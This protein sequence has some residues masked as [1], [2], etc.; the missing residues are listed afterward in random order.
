[1]TDWRQLNAAT[2]RR[3]RLFDD[4][5]WKAELQRL[6]VGFP[7]A[8]ETE[9]TEETEC[10][11]YPCDFGGPIA[12]IVTKT[13]IATNSQARS[14]FHV[15]TAAGTE[16]S[17]V[18]WPHFGLLTGKWADLSTFVAAFKDGTIRSFDATGEKRGFFNILPMGGAVRSRERTLKTAAIGS[19]YI[20]VVTNGGEILVNAS[21]FESKP[22]KIP[23]VPAHWLRSGKAG[24]PT[25]IKALHLTDE[26]SNL[27]L[28]IATS[29][30]GFFKYDGGWHSVKLLPAGS[31]DSSLKISKI[32]VSKS[33]RFLAA[34]TDDSF[35]CIINGSSLLTA[36]Q[37][38]DSILQ[39]KCSL[40]NS[41]AI[42][43]QQI[44]WVA[45]HCLA[46]VVPTPTAFNPKQHC[47]F[48]GGP[49]KRWLDYVQ[50]SWVLISSEIDGL[51]YLT[52]SQSG[53]IQL[54]SEA[55]DA[56]FG[57][58]SCDPAAMVTFAQQRALSLS[59]NEAEEL[60][61][62]ASV[63]GETDEDVSEDAEGDA[64]EAARNESNFKFSIERSR[65]ENS[66]LN[67]FFYHN[68]WEFEKN[69]NPVQ[70]AEFG[71][72]EAALILQSQSTDEKKD[73]LTKILT[74][75]EDEWDP[76]SIVALFKSARLCMDH[77]RMQDNTEM[78]IKYQRLLR[79][80]KML[81]T[82]RNRPA[83]IPLTFHQL[84][85][86][87]L[88]KLV[89]SLFKRRHFD[90]ALSVVNHYKLNPLYY[91]ERELL[92]SENTEMTSLRN[93]YRTS[94]ETLEK[95]VSLNCVNVSVH[96][97]SSTAGLADDELLDS[98][99]KKIGRTFLTDRV[100]ARQAAW[101]A[102]R[103]SRTQFARKLM[104]DEKNH[105]VKMYFCQTVKDYAGMLECGIQTLN[106]NFLDVCLSNIFPF[107]CTSR[108]FDD[109]Q[110]TGTD[111]PHPEY[112]IQSFLTAYNT[113]LKSAPTNSVLKAMLELRQPLYYTMAQLR[114]LSV[115]AEASHPSISFSKSMGLNIEHV[116]N[117]LANIR[118][119][120]I[121]SIDA[122]SGIQEEPTST[123]IDLGIQNT[124]I[125][126]LMT[127]PFSSLTAAVLNPHGASGTEG[128]KSNLKLKQEAHNEY[129]VSLRQLIAHCKS[130]ARSEAVHCLVPI[131]SQ[132]SEILRF[133]AELA[134]LCKS[135]APSLSFVGLGRGNRAAR[136]GTAIIEWEGLSLYKTGETLIFHSPSIPN[137]QKKLEE[138][139]Q[140]FGV[141]KKMFL[142][143]K[144]K[145][146]A[147]R[148]LWAEFLELAIEA[149]RAV[150]LH[151]I[152]RPGNSG[153]LSI[154]GAISSAFN[155]QTV[156]EQS[157]GGAQFAA[158]LSSRFAA[159]LGT[160]STLTSTLSSILAAV[161]GR[162]TSLQFHPLLPDPGGQSSTQ[163]LCAQ[164]LPPSLCSRLHVLEFVNTAIKYDRS[165]IALAL[166]PYISPVSLREKYGVYLGLKDAAQCQKFCH[167]AVESALARSTSSQ[168]SASAGFV[169][170]L[171]SK[172]TTVQRNPLSAWMSTWT[173]NIPDLDSLKLPQLPATQKQPEAA[174]DSSLFVL[175]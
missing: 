32:A 79:D 174:A 62:T 78:T 109:R 26:L 73:A 146:L 175:Q 129:Y 23:P 111:R 139:R 138:F 50:S 127:S 163:P 55:T 61:D 82:L 57:A 106:P 70:D 107:L 47:L 58:G 155:F 164:L 150:P 72:D 12:V 95:A 10:V 154:T 102:V 21:L 121:V 22:L 92:S 4:L 84:N 56:V 14:G 16:I 64:W 113:L 7:T 147:R 90:V 137:A 151:T 142:L 69:V 170:K 60:E 48:I 49:S 173:A 166:V 117:Q 123:S 114:L 143:W 29:T 171:I 24:R 27:I 46:L 11:I 17:H 169:L 100:I 172:A 67:F 153:S 167:D 1:M 116:W 9:E 53:W 104:A 122:S 130:D 91:N 80:F 88:S 41:P 110:A 160:E 71:Q 97:D 132:E 34:F 96:S 19:R 83:E 68:K 168:D 66:D 105:L 37:R 140:R 165:D 75:L 149:V 8:E 44:G 40:I 87:G 25:Q 145:A 28:L 74:A 51:R 120:A 98:L 45:D 38:D 33:R 126:H 108:I 31:L 99:I 115:S 131:L 63:N 93:K 133:Q 125:G 77:L 6:R 152:Y 101:A 94:I 5:A 86:L 85:F 42:N 148:G 18:P 20:A 141:D 128:N 157:E 136:E 118:R 3:Q 134:I 124:F 158:Y 135:E 59:Q 36:S 119:R 76:L 30:G 2:Y 89:T 156:A 39:V 43:V 162:Q 159:P 103:V 15:Y 112:Y 54:V 144:I 161:P 35:V 65:L 81:I 52:E 13:E